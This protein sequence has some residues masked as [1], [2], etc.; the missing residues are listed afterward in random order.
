M[1]TLLVLVA[2][3]GFPVSA[4][5]QPVA[6][7]GRS[8][9]VSGLTV[10]SRT[11][12]C[13]PGDPNGPLATSTKFDAPVDVKNKRTEESEGTR[14]VVQAPAAGARNNDVDYAKINPKVAKLIQAKYPRF[15]AFIVC[16][17]VFKGVN[18]LHVSQDG[19]DDFEV[20]FSNGTLE[21]VAK[22]FHALQ[23][24]WETGFR[25]Y[26]PQP[27]TRQFEDLL[28]SIEEG[29][30]NYAALTPDAA[31]R[32]QAQWPTLQTLLKDG[33]RR[34]G[35]RFLRHEEDGS[36]VY[37]ATYEHRQVVWT[38]LPPKAGGKFTDVTYSEKAG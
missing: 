8:T 25:N 21:W 11:G 2:A 19:Y 24:T 30:P 23:L 34:K 1:R 14:A 6:D 5:A 4:L 29:R 20:D 28:K 15:Q 12:Q 10:E 37:L 18:F 31:S 33:D 32:L 17:G 22:P 35:L 7:D 38:V 27:A 13:P 3:A 36:Y 9:E 16:Q 26:Y